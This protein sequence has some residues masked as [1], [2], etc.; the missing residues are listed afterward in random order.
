MLATAVYNPHYEFGEGQIEFSE[1]LGGIQDINEKYK[2]TKNGEGYEMLHYDVQNMYPNIIN[3]HLLDCPRYL[4]YLHLVRSI[5]KKKDPDFRNFVKV[6]LNAFFGKAYAKY[7]SNQLLDIGRSIIILG[8]IYIVECARRLNDAGV[9]ITK[10]KTD[11]IYVLNQK[12]KKTKEICDNIFEKLKESF[13]LT[14]EFEGCELYYMKD[15]SNAF[16]KSE[17]IGGEVGGKKQV[18]LI[19]SKLITDRKDYDLKDFFMIKSSS[20]GLNRIFYSKNENKRI[21]LMSNPNKNGTVS[22]VG[23]C[24][25]VEIWN[26]NIY[27]AE[28][29][30]YLLDNFD[31]ERVEKMVNKNV[32]T[33]I[34]SCNIDELKQFLK[35]YINE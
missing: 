16:S 13:G 32:Y 18:P 11:G 17:Q 5:D 19:Y 2:Y 33:P 29:A 3:T 24:D 14:M 35:G 6:G 30:Q 1:N 8:H 26:E 9:I 20:L 15:K 28:T 22:K 7:D 25:D 23:G 34:N 21:T 12:H 10:I 31:F 4:E 27:T